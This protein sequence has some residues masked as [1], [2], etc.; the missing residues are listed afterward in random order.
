VDISPVPAKNA[1]NLPEI[2]YRDIHGISAAH[3][4]IQTIAS[5]LPVC[6]THTAIRVNV[7]WEYRNNV[8]RVFRLT[9]VPDPMG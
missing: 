1:R 3:F 8:R 7:G 4:V 5:R 2:I 9:E 6:R